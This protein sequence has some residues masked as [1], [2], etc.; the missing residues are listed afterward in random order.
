MKEFAVTC[1]GIYFSSTVECKNEHNFVVKA[2]F[3][4]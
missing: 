2:A 1:N 4:N 3:F